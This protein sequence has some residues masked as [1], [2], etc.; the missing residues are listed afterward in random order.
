L[1]FFLVCAIFGSCCFE[2]SCPTCREL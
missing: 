1:V 2:D